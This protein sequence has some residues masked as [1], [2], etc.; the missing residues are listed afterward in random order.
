MRE[1]H[2]K[3]SFASSEDLQEYAEEQTGEFHETQAISFFLCVSFLKRSTAIGVIEGQ[4]SEDI[5]SKFFFQVL[6]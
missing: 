4:I 1:D 2:D 5:S 6:I 3:D